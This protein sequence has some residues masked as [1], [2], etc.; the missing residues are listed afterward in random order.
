MC[1]SA[2]LSFSSSSNSIS[3]FCRRTLFTDGRMETLEK[4]FDICCGVT[5]SSPV[6]KSLLVPIGVMINSTNTSMSL[7]YSRSVVMS[8]RTVFSA[9]S[10]MAFGLSS[11]PGLLGGGVSLS[12]DKVLGSAPALGVITALVLGVLVDIGICTASGDLGWTGDDWLVLVGGMRI[13]IMALQL[14]KE[15]P[16]RT[17]DGVLAGEPLTE[18]ERIWLKSGGRRLRLISPEGGLADV[19]RLRSNGDV[20]FFPFSL[21]NGGATSPSF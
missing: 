15:D 16:D 19:E 17:R 18:K 2:L 20:L 14:S 8:S 9:C 10:R 3:R 4:M 13:G 7:M 1:I 11:S 5:R 6:K 12:G 21:C